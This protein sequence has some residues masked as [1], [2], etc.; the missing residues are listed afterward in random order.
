MIHAAR[1]AES[2]EG[3]FRKATA[4]TLT[5]TAETGSDQPLSKDGRVTIS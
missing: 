3:R 2:G 1:V 4:V 5:E